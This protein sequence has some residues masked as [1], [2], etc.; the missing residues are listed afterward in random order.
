VL[1]TS[2]VQSTLEI[3]ATDEIHTEDR[4]HGLACT[5]PNNGILIQNAKQ[6][7]DL[8]VIMWCQNDQKRNK[9]IH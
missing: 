6:S 8:R 9:P 4:H 7:T 2:D 1:A 5:K 3:P